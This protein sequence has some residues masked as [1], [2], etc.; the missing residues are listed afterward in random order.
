M[1]LTDKSAIN[2]RWREY[3]KTL[4]DAEGKPGKEKDCKRSDLLDREIKAA[5][6]DLKNRKA[7]G[8]DEIQTE[9]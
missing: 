3:I 1:L 8:I 2:E 9:F 4:Y 5:I 7:V 6:K